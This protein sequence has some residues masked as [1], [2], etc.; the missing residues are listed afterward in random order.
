MDYNAGILHYLN[1]NSNNNNIN[2]DIQMCY[3]Y[4]YTLVSLA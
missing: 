3:I 4:I 2:N 1:N